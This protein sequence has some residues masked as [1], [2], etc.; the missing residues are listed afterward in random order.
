MN[1]DI[2]NP[3]SKGNG[4]GAEAECLILFSGGLGMCYF[5]AGGWWWHGAISCLGPAEIQSCVFGEDATIVCSIYLYKCYMHGHFYFCRLIGKITISNNCCAQFY[6]SYMH[7]HFYTICSNCSAQFYKSYVPCYF[8]FSQIS[9]LV[10]VSLKSNSDYPVNSLTS[11]NTKSYH[12]NSLRNLEPNTRTKY[13][14]PKS[15]Y[16]NSRTRWVT[17]VSS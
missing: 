4:M 13:Y 5:L 12:K 6:K 9:Y 2:V 8:H 17:V 14:N 3:L 15:N 11:Q 10:S 7:G 16:K 1:F